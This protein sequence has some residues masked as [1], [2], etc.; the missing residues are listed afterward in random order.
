MGTSWLFFAIAAP[1]LYG[2]TNFIDKF[3]IEKHVSDPVVLTVLGGGISFI[4]G[5]IFL[6]LHNFPLL[7]PFQ[8]TLIVISGALIEFALL[9]YYEALSLDDTSRIVPL[10]QFI[11]IIVLVLSYLFLGERLTSL[12][13]LG[14]F[15]VFIGGFF[16]S[17]K[18]LNWKIFELRKSFWYMMLA[19]LTY[20]VASVILKFVI[21][22]L[23]FWGT[24]A[25]ELIAGELVVV[26]MLSIRGYRSRIFD[27]LRNFKTGLWGIISGNEVV[28]LL[29]RLSGF[30]AF[31]LAPVSLVS[32]MGGFQ[33]FFV[34]IF[35][36][37]LSVWFPRVIK[38]DIGK[39]TVLVKLASI[40]LIFVGIWIVGG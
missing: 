29:G 9:P 23:N 22:P 18:E 19:C 30:Y 31:A 33:P 8:M 15:F 32:V 39:T 14:F 16:L 11:P 27:Q 37:A 2:A 28:Y 24:I 35:G 17:L 1:A 20:A 6:A 3:L 40:V 26:F 5:L 10:F 4:F 7:D 12:Q 38:E 36:L 34:L 13:V 25:Y 21:T